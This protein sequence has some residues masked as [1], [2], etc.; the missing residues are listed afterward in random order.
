MDYY[1]ILGVPKNASQEDIRKA[2]KKKSMQHHPDRPDGNEEQF[3]LVNE[4]YSILS[5][6]HKRGMYDHQQNGGGEAFDFNRHHRQ[7]NGNPFENTAF[8]DI[9]QEMMRQGYKHNPRAMN[10]DITIAVRITLEE[11]ITGKNIL[12]TY[13]LRSGK[14]QTVEINIP[15]GANENQRIKFKELGDDSFPGPRGNLFVK[16]E[17]IPHKTWLRDNSDIYTEH[18]INVL[19]MIVGGVI[20]IE[21][22][23]KRHVK[24]NIPKGTQNGQKFKLPGYGLPDIKQGRKGDA[25]VILK[26]VIPNIEDQSILRKLTKLRNNLDKN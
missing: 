12:A 14:E 10:R 26:P 1:S 23:D 18:N 20:I 25:F 9:Y 19:D 4:A 15:A 17:I 3:K 13:R 5:D 7:T 21:T 6:P 22:L 8:N 2:Y 16:I 11:I 24:L